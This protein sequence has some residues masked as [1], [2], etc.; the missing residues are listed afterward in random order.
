VSA[1]QSTESTSR[2]YGSGRM[3]VAGNGL[4]P[5]SALPSLVPEVSPSWLL[6]GICL[7]SFPAGSGHGSGYAFVHDGHNYEPCPEF[8]SG[9]MLRTR[10]LFIPGPI[11]RSRKLRA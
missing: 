10:T 9:S 5:L 4:E 8:S 11:P 7:A 3:Q 6:P 2:Q 1:H